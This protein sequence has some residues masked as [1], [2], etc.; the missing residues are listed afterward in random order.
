M[1]KVLISLPDQLATRMRATIPDRQRSKI[2]AT[3]LEI[4][5]LR[6]EKALYEC[7]LAVENDEA[8]KSDMAIWDV[9]VNDGLNE[10][11]SI[12]LRLPKEPKS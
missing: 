8:L 9:T 1:H 12:K 3:L 4:E 10:E 11:E 2:I 7:A 5:I 6:R